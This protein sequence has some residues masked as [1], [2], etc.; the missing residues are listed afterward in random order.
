M[1]LIDADELIEQFK[2]DKNF[3][4]NAWG[5]F[6]NLP[7]NDKARVDEL[8]NCIAQVFKAPTIE[9]PTWIPVTE[10]LPTIDDSDEIGMV[11]ALTR[12]GFGNCWWWKV[13]VEM[14]SNF[15]HWMPLPTPPKDGDT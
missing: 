2:E 7:E 9:V 6:R 3:F 15:T 13:I 8:D 10:R 12:N 1:R 11:L 14:P 5:G 4:V